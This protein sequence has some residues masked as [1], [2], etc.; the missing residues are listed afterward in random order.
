MAV[1]VITDKKITKF[2]LDDP[3]FKALPKPKPEEVNGNIVEEDVH[4][5]NIKMMRNNAE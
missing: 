2:D 4:I 5:I 1:Q 3:N